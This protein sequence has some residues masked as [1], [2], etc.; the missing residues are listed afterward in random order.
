MFSYWEKNTF[1][2]TVDF[3]VLGSGIVGLTTAIFI[4]QK[5]PK[6]SV[7]ILERGMLPSGAST[8]NAGFACFGSMGELMDD[9]NYSDE[10]SVYQLLLER[11]KGLEELKYLIGEQSMDFQM[12]GGYELFKTNQKEEFE[13]C[14]DK[15]NEV[16]NHL[17]SSFSGNVYRQVSNTFGFKD[18]VGIIQNKFEGQIDTGLMMQSLLRLA[19]DTG[20]AILNGCEISEIEEETQEVHLKTKNQEVI[21]TRQLII[22]TNGFAKQF[23]PSYDIKPA[24]AQVLITKPIENLTFEGTFHYDKGYYYFRNTHN[25]VLLGGGR[26]LAFEEEATTEIENTSLIIDHLK[27]LLKDVILPNTPHE[28]D[29][30]WAGI[31]GVG[32][33]KKPFV[34]QVSNRVFC[35]VKLG[36][37]GVALGT[38]VGKKLSDLS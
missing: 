30:S 31:M 25:R 38:L 3:T 1:L 29:Y 24:R 37:M 5:Y 16:N 21:K 19:K 14:L 34:E 28:I 35:G 7:Q 22:C 32:Q 4:K 17:Y 36:G 27:S 33:N 2:P 20:I 6:A 9:F 8:K 11:I 13:A 26:N 15:M 12:L 18:L 23:L 10:A